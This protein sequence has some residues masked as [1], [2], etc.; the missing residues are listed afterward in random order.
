MASQIQAKRSVSWC[1][2]FK[3]GQETYATLS[4]T[5]FR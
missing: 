4:L 3:Q 2:I 1:S 5:R